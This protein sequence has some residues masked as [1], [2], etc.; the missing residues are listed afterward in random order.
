V[1]LTKAFEKAK[2]TCLAPATKDVDVGEKK[3][4]II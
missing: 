4:R 1:A 3:I 2:G